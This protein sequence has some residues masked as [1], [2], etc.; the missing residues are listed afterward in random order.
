[1]VRLY[2]HGEGVG[3]VASHG[4]GVRGGEGWAHEQAA[5]RDLTTHD[6]MAP[7][8]PIFSAVATLDMVVIKQYQGNGFYKL[9]DK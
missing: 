9:M 3:S 8:F 2:V 7:H 1:M 5:G 6:F 4:E